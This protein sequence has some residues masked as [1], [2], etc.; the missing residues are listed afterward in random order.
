MEVKYT[1]IE[2][3]AKLVA[4]TVKSDLTPALGKLVELDMLAAILIQGQ[5]A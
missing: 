1:G 2:T 4:H 5:P 3:D